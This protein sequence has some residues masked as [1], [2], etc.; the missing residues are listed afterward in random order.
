MKPWRYKASSVDIQ[1]CNS[2]LYSFVVIPLWN[3]TMV[4]SCPLYNLKTLQDI[5]MKFHRNIKHHQ[6]MCTT[7]DCNS[8]LYI[9]GVIPLYPLFAIFVNNFC[10]IPF[11]Q[12]IDSSFLTVHFINSCESIKHLLVL[13]KSLHKL[14][15]N[16]QY[17]RAHELSKQWGMNFRY[18]AQG[19]NLKK[20]FI[21]G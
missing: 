6:T 15:Y 16:K 18:F 3:L 11:L 9:L 17:S 20:M 21:R 19:V 1:N 13:W 2:C 4:I 7:Q 10:L 8:C 5:F 14:S 12:T